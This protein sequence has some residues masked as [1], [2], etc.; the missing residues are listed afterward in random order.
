MCTI[1]ASEEQHP[2]LTNNFL[3][4]TDKL[5]LTLPRHVTYTVGGASPHIITY[6]FGG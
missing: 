1:G 2:I 6:T 4:V 5:F 3:Y